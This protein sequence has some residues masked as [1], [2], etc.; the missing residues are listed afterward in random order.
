MNE[1]RQISTFKFQIGCKSI[2]SDIEMFMEGG[3]VRVRQRE[4]EK[5]I[6][7]HSLALSFYRYASTNKRQAKAKKR[8]KKFNNFS[9]AK[10]S[11]LI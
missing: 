7:S 1:I 11:N 8:K 3:R 2:K 4:R 6:I 10:F 5:I 9:A